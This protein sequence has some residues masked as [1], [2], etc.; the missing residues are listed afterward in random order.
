MPVRESE[1]GRFEST[2]GELAPNPGID[3]P[4][5]AETLAD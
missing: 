4:A 2:G 3:D 1:G 5:S